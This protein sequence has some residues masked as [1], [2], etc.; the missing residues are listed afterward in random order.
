MQ[1]VEILVNTSGKN[2]SYTLSC[3]DRRGQVH[4][5]TDSGYGSKEDSMQ[6]I[7]IQAHIQ[8]LGR[9]TKSAK[10]DI[11]TDSQYVNT[12]FKEGWIN[13]WQQNGWK[14]SKGKPVANA[15]LWKALLK[16]LSMHCYK[17]QYKPSHGANYSV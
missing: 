5:I 9:M 16:G 7:E 4:T 14:N 11:I 3:T 13:R 8:A 1:S 10:L 2:F 12:A 6:S 15:E 17:I